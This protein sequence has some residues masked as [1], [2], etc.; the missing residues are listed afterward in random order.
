LTVKPITTTSSGAS[1]VVTR[2]NT[3]SV[4]V[5]TR[6]DWTEC[7]LHKLIIKGD[8]QCSGG[9]DCYLEGPQ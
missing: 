2:A 3:D 6:D 5:N 4:F 7:S 1:V 8:S 9:Q